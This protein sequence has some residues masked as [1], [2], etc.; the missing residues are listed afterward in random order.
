MHTSS[1]LTRFLPVAVVAAAM[2]AAGIG[3][4][5]LAA[6]GVGAAKSAAVEVRC[7]R[8]VASG[9]E[10]CSHAGTRAYLMNSISSY[11]GS[12]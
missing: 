7:P 1:S 10:T 4:V 11:L 5:S 3:A 8:D 9:K 6:G 2:W 12:G